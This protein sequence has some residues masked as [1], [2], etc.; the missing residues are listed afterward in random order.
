MLVLLA[1]KWPDFRA[2]SGKGAEAA[3]L[4][5]AAAAAVVVAVVDGKGEVEG[6][7]GAGVMSDDDGD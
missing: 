3:V 5:L 7:P 1:P 4:F 2:S 6:V